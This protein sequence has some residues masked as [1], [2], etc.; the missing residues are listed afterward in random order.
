MMDKGDV[1]KTICE[2]MLV[3]DTRTDEMSLSRMTGFGIKCG[4][5]RF[6]SLHY[7][8]ICLDVSNGL[9]TSK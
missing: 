7:V 5:I 6:R 8:C 9:I 4:C 1:V 3:G 2:H